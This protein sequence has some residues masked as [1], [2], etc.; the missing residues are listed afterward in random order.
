[1]WPFHEVDPRDLPVGNPEPGLGPQGAKLPL[2]EV[3]PD[4]VLASPLPTWATFDSF[5]PYQ[6]HACS[7]VGSSL[8]T[9]QCSEQM[10]VYP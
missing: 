9:Q 10:T 1:M 2:E 3:C 7:E 5:V 4:P 8:E 6:R